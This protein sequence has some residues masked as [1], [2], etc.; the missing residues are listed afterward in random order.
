MENK[1]IDV[2]AEI[3]DEDNQE[4]IKEEIK[5]N[6]Q[7]QIIE[8]INLSVSDIKYEDAQI[9]SNQIESGT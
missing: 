2:Q 9:Q 8:S 3:N 6:T 7:R 4:E 1:L 5:E